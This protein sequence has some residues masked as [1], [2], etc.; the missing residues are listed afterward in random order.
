MFFQPVQK[1]LSQYP[2][3][4]F[5]IRDFVFLIF[6]HQSTRHFVRHAQAQKQVAF[7]FFQKYTLNP[8]LFRVEKESGL[9]YIFEKIEMQL[10]SVLA[11]VERNGVLIDAEKLKKQSHE[12]EKRV[13]DIEKDIFELSG[14]TFNLNWAKQLQE[15]LFTQLQLPVL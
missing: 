11:R 13:A 2:R 15:I 12:L 6:R 7:Q 14:K 5:L 4:V 1:Y 9:K 10:V 3:R 8:I